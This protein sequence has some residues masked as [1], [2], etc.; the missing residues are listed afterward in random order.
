MKRG[1]AFKSDGP[2]RGAEAPSGGIG[3]SSPTAR[4]RKLVKVNETDLTSI[5][6]ILEALML[7]GFAAAWPFNIARAW[8]ARTAIGVS[9]Q[10]YVIIEIAYI[11]GMLSKFAK[12]DVNYVLGF[13][14]LDFALVFVAILI[15]FRNKKID[16]LKGRSDHLDRRRRLHPDEG[17]APPILPNIIF[18][19]DDPLRTTRWKP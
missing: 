9:M 7:L 4:S 14:V 10:F 2:L 3:A 16:A 8:K 17:C 11:C 13:Y 6:Y 1:D 12:D 19:T 5:G 15:Y 18:N